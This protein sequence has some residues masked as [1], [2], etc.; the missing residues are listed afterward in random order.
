MEIWYHDN[1]TSIL[2]F[3]RHVS[4][5]GDIHMHN[6]SG[7][8]PDLMKMEG[9]FLIWWWTLI[10]VERV[11]LLIRNCAMLG[12]IFQPITEIVRPWAFFGHFNMAVVRESG[13]LDGILFLQRTSKTP[14]R[15]LTVYLEGDV[16]YDNSTFVMTRL[17]DYRQIFPE[18]RVYCKDIQTFTYFIEW[19]W[20]EIFS[21]DN[22]H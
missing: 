15:Q 5:R 22:Q 14:E 8:I 4:T 16:C 17:H 3:L 6:S 10:Y 1:G 19:K 13:R 2:Q 21:F 11:I 9:D 20:K 12:Q 7:C 18:S